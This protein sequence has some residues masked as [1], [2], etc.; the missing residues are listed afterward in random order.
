MEPRAPPRRVRSVFVPPRR[1]SVTPPAG[2]SRS[3]FKRA[4][5]RERGDTWAG[6]VSRAPG[7]TSHTRPTPPSSP[8]TIRVRPAPVGRSGAS[9]ALR[10]SL[11]GA[12]L[13]R[14]EDRRWD[15]DPAD[16]ADETAS[17]GAKLQD[18]YGRMNE[19]ISSMTFERATA[20]L[21]ASP[22]FGRLGGAAL[23]GRVIV[24]RT[25]RARRT[26]SCALR[27][28]SL[29]DRITGAT[30]RFDEVD[31]RVRGFLG[32]TGVISLRISIGLGSSGSA[33]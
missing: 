26:L 29:V 7:G 24:L 12:S 28:A 32:T 15:A 9:R 8:V 21:R 17:I 18:T 30:R 6:A 31:E 16:F 4:T 14:R 2:S 19:R 13:D 11:A 22:A 33:C 23:R 20:D 25:G 5:P 27:M 3:S 1:R 10:G